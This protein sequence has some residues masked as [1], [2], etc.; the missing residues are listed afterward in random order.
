MVPF[1]IQFV[2]GPAWT[3]SAQNCLVTSKEKLDR[4][5]IAPLP[6]N[7]KMVKFG[8]LKCYKSVENAKHHEGIEVYK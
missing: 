6:I 2:S 3:V 4:F 5:K 1:W 8:W 7:F